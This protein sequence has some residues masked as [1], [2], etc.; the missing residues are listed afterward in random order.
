MILY[1]G[2][3]ILAW[4]AGGMIA[5]DPLLRD[6][7]FLYFPCRHLVGSHCHNRRRIEMLKIKTKLDKGDVLHSW[8]SLVAE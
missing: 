8:V 3:G 2:G 6:I 5:G 4:T 1:L 7:F